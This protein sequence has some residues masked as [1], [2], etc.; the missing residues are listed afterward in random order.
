MDVEY[1]RRLPKEGLRFTHTRVVVKSLLNGKMDTE[2]I[3]SNEDDE[4]LCIGL[5]VVLLIDS[6]MKF[7]ERGQVKSKL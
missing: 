5:Q 4:I 1:K 6:G 3:I 7:N 2:I